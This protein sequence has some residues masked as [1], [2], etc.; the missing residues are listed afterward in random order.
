MGF[1]SKIA[2]FLKRLYFKFWWVDV[3]YPVLLSF[4]LF[5]SLT[6]LLYTGQ[7]HRRV[8]SQIELRL[9]HWSL[10]MAGPRQLESASQFLTV[11]LREDDFSSLNQL[12]IRDHKDTSLINYAFLLDRLLDL[13]A[14]TIFIHWQPDA[15]PSDSHYKPLLQVVEK[16][17]TLDRQLYFAIHPSLFKGLPLDFKAHANLLEADPCDAYLQTVCVFDEN[18]ETWIMQKLSRLYWIR[19]RSKPSPFYSALSRNLPPQSHAYLLYYNDY[20]DFIDFSF[21]DIIEFDGFGVEAHQTFF[22]GKSIFIGNSVVQGKEGMIKTADINRVKTILDPLTIS[23]R[24]FGTPLH[25]FWAQHAQMFH[26]NAL[27]GVVPRALSL[28]VA[29]LLAVSIILI[30]RRFGA[31]FSLAVFLGFACLAPLFNIL[32][33]RFLNLYL[34]IF[35]SLYAGLLAFL[36]ATFAKL[37]IESFYHWRLRIQEKSDSELL[38]AK[39]NFISLLSHNLNTPVAKMQGI[40]SAVESFCQ[41]EDLRDD[42]RK[43]QGLVSTIQLAIR[44]VLVTTALEEHE[45]NHEVLTLGT[46]VQGFRESM[47]KTLDRLGITVHFTLQESEL[48]TIPLRFDKRALTMGLTSLLI[49]FEKTVDE[50]AIHL[51]FAAVQDEN[52]RVL[53]ACSLPARDGKAEGLASILPSGDSTSLLEDVAGAVLTSL[54][55][56]YAGSLVVGKHGITLY[57]HPHPY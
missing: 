26:D 41:K 39:S 37:S 51:L 43:A 32:A 25:K 18:W 24:L 15:F 29:F 21:R 22:K 30:L 23:T 27:V 48:A 33:I 13:G 17:K 44:S 9:I 11:S 49:L 46:F 12:H 3:L 38:S 42:L 28:T 31:M 16:A 52:E 7:K 36:L 10:G 19:P 14:Q 2:P 4:L 35:N 57:L 55:K 45:L 20:A 34:P 47:R 40:L 54:I 5:W 53:L 6:Y 50:G 8:S 1:S 56:T